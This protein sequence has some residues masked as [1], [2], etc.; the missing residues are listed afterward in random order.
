MLPR[1]DIRELL[2][3]AATAP[4]ESDLSE[5]HSFSATDRLICG[6]IVHRLWGM[7]EWLR[8]D[9]AAVES[10]PFSV[11]D[12]HSRRGDQVGWHAYGKER[13]ISCIL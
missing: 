7:A 4:S 9:A 2:P 1:S 13:Q 12:G 5:V 8:H 6:S 3:P 10:G 11:Y